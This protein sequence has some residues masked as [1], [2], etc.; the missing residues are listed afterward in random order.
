MEQERLLSVRLSRLVSCDA[1]LDVAIRYECVLP[2][3]VIVVEEEEPES[4]RTDLA[5][6]R[7]NPT[8]KQNEIHYRAC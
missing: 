8:D 1:R 7:A 5:Q 3:V 6:N 4:E 2:A